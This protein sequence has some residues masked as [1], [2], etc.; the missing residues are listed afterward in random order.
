MLKKTLFIFSLLI[1]F[2]VQAENNRFA[3]RDADLY[4]ATKFLKTTYEQQ[5]D[6]FVVSPLSVYA[7]TTLLANGATGE[8]FYELEENILNPNK[9]YGR[10]F[11][12]DGKNRTDSKNASI[13]HINKTLQSYI[14]SKTQFEINNSIWGNEF[15]PSYIE[16]LKIQLNV[17][18]NPLPNHTSVINNWVKEKTKNRIQ[19]ILNEEETTSDQL[20][21]VNTIYFKDEWVTPFSQK[22]TTVQDFHS[23]DGQ[24]DQVNMMSRK[25]FL[26]YYEDDKM[27]S[28]QLPYKN[29][30]VLH[31]FLPKEG[32]NFDDFIQKLTVNDLYLQY[33]PVPVHL[34]LPKVKSDSSVQMV[35]YFKKWQ[36]QSIFNDKTVSLYMLSDK[37]KIVTD[38]IH[39][40]NIDID[41]KGTEAAAATLNLLSAGAMGYRP[42]DP[43]QWYIP[44]FADRPFVFMMNNG[45]FIGVYTKGKLVDKQQTH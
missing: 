39:K 22:Q 15:R 25:D 28:I 21:L 3:P 37:P 20:Y 27:Q 43:Q 36:I 45:D 31:I 34:K 5:K 2:A 8:S 10:V 19:N 33:H 16:T 38:I 18:A 26:N 14:N 41:E 32:V 9:K 23:L 7:A 11:A 30:D 1:S 17:E 42:L 35:N 4:L 12:L 13:N 44:F 29:K 6:N 40:A 24:V